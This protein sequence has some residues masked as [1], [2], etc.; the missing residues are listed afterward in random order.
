MVVFTKTLAIY[1]IQPTIVFRPMIYIMWG[2][3]NI[4]KDGDYAK[5]TFMNNYISPTYSWRQP[6]KCVQGSHK[7]LACVTYGKKIGTSC[8]SRQ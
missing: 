1:G 3:G 6:N 8:M 7:I 4:I 2:W 5:G